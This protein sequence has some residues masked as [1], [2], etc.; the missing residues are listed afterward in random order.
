MPVSTIFYS[1]GKGIARYVSLTIGVTTFLSAIKKQHFAQVGKV[2]F[3]YIE[4]VENLRMYEVPLPYFNLPK[5]W[6]QVII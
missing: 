3:F 4:L 6:K 5:S 2:L 1:N